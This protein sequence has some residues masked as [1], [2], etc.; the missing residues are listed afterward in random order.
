M[1]KVWLSRDLDTQLPVSA[2]CCSTGSFWGTTVCIPK[3]VVITMIS[4]A[5]MGGII[6]CFAKH[7]WCT[8]VVRA[9]NED[10]L[11]LNRCAGQQ[12]QP[13]WMDL[14]VL[15]QKRQF[16]ASKME[17]FFVSWRKLCQGNDLLKMC[18]SVHQLL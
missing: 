9:V 10:H 11:D 15:K 14:S 1:R 16:A 8:M 2:I 7:T 4:F 5:V 3:A 17:Q 13:C 6:N 12:M 18:S